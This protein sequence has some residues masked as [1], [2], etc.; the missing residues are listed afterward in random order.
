MAY[1]NVGTPKFYI[2]TLSWLSSLG[3]GSYNSE[4]NV[5]GFDASIPYIHLGTGGDEW[6]TYDCGEDI[7]IPIN[8]C[9]LL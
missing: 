2:D 1:H 9:A 5:Y 8:F 7:K 6:L 3:I 4:E